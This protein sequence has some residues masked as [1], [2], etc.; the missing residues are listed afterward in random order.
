[1]PAATA[2]R[3]T[4]SRIASSASIR[5]PPVTPAP[6]ASSDISSP[7]RPSNVLRIT[8]LRGALRAQLEALDLA[9]GGLRELD[10][11]FDPA[12]IFVG[13]KRALRVLLQ[14]QRQRV[15]GLVG[16]LEHHESLRLDQ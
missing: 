13:R 5:I 9:G 2:R 16:G 8:N 14:C 11:K 15:A 4:A 3:S 1:M 10:A 6:N 7:V 12:R